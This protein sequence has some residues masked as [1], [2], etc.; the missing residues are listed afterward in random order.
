MLVVISG[1]AVVV[2]SEVGAVGADQHQR[3]S[4]VVRG[5]GRV[6]EGVCGVRCRT[7][8]GSPWSRR[9]RPPHFVL[10]LMAGIDVLQPHHFP[11]R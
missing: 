11:S 8:A 5:Y 9:T 6:G 1:I 4:V 2:E 3:D 10:V 7:Y